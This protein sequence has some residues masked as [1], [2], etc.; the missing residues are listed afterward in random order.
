[1]LARISAVLLRMQ[2]AEL[3]SEKIDL[4][5]C[6][7]SAIVNRSGEGSSQDK[8]NDN[9]GRQLGAD[10][11]LPILVYIIAKCGFYSAEIE[12]EFMWGL[13]HPSLLNGESGYYITALCSAC[14][15]LKTFMGGNEIIGVPNDKGT[16]NV[17]DFDS[18]I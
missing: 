18:Q 7:V 4:W 15:V 3:P 14:H 6:A 16:L 1:M 8:E 2:E 9:S 12:A 10:D 17:S 13:L 11:F 5:L